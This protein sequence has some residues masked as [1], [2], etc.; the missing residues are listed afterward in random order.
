MSSDGPDDEE[1]A[2]ADASRAEL[3]RE[4]I[5]AGDAARERRQGDVL[6][7]VGRIERLASTA[8]DD[9]APRSRIEHGCAEVRTLVR[10]EPLVAAEYLD[11]MRRTVEDSS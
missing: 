2:D 10:D 11:A 7:R 6:R 1:V 4:L 3:A 9:D 8:L 5:E